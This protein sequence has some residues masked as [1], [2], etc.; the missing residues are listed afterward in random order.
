VEVLS[1]YKAVNLSAYQ[2]TA[3]KSVRYM[4]KD[5]DSL[6]CFANEP[7]DA[8]SFLAKSA[9]MAIPIV[10]FIR[11]M[12]GTEAQTQAETMAANADIEIAQMEKT[13]ITLKAIN[14]R[15]KEGEH[16][17]KGLID[18]SFPIISGLDTYRTT[19]NKQPSVYIMKQVE[20]GIMLTKALKAVIEVDILTAQGLLNGN[21]GLV[22]STVKR[23]VFNAA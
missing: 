20:E 2:E 1:Y 15:I 19:G 4:V 14:A 13:M 11:A 3:I 23:E 21:S 18:R 12:G 9:F 17:I 7:K 8:L 22:F 10:S 5:I 6:T 16:I